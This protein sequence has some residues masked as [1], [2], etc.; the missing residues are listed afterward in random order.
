MTIIR[1][2]R[3][4]AAE[5]TASNPILSAGE[6]GFETDTNKLKIGDGTQTWTARPY[7]TGS[8]GGGSVT[9]VAGVSPVSGNVPLDADDILDGTV[10]KQFT[11]SERVKLAGVATGATANS[12]DA[13][14]RDLAL[15]TG[16]LDVVT[17]TINFDTALASLMPE[18]SDPDP[19]TIV[20]RR[21]G[22]GAVAGGVAAFPDEFTPLVQVGD[23]I[24]SAVGT[25]PDAL[26]QSNRVLTGLPRASTTDG[27]YATLPAAFDAVT[28][29]LGAKSGDRYRMN[30]WIAYRAVTAAGI[31]WRFK[32]G[33]AA[34]TNRL[35]NP[36]FN[37]DITGW[38]PQTGLTLAHETTTVQEGAGSMKVTVAGTVTTLS[39]LG[40]MSNYVSV[41]AAQQFA[42]A[43]QI[44][45]GSATARNARIDIQYADSTGADLNFSTGIVST[46][47]G[48]SVA[49]SNGSWTRHIG[50]SAHRSGSPT[51]PSIAPAGAVKARVKITF[52]Q[53]LAG[54]V[55]YVD[56]AQLEPG[57]PIAAWGA[58][59]GGSSILDIQ[60][61][62]SGL[63]STGAITAA[64]ARVS[65][66]I[67]FP[68]VA[69]VG[70]DAQGQGTGT[71][72]TLLGAF[73]ILVG[74]TGL[75]DQ[76]IEF[77][78]AQ[79]AANGTAT[80][81]QAAHSTIAKVQEGA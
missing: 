37:T 36:T 53:V 51:G 64:T 46:D 20:R 10:G 9:T 33:S 29:I 60:G 12:S 38:W 76:T 68:T 58:T 57:D 47:L 73:D 34:L 48:N 56:A 80:Q 2:R 74:G 66:S 40:V 77:E 79:L 54:D 81:I 6:P 17:Q 69:T 4:T 43:A 28:K 65:T 71:D 49:T 22:T 52:L 31:S 42:A 78:W 14:L 39:N 13:S 3:G 24:A 41:V 55:F 45:R 70:V 5:W 11:A 75:I 30:L 27:S 44:R 7:L 8:G 25:G 16:L 72:A 18:S 15:A 59:G 26:V 32:A 35:G 21:V 23:M 63:P 19:D 62:F 1:L 50:D 67:R 61:E